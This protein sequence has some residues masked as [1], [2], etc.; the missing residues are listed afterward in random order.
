[1]SKLAHS[2]QETMDEIER[3]SE[4]EGDYIAS[5]EGP[6][7]DKPPA[8][9]SLEELDKCI[10]INE[11]FKARKNADVIIN[12]DRATDIELYCLHAVRD[13]LATAPKLVA[14][15]LL[16]KHFSQAHTDMV[17][18]AEYRE[19]YIKGIHD[20]VSALL[21]GA[22]QSP[23]MD[24]ETAPKDVE[25]LLGWWRSGLERQWECTSGL[26]GST[27]G[28][29]LHGQ[30]THWQPLPA[31]PT[32]NSPQDAKASHNHGESDPSVMP[33]SSGGEQ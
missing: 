3:R 13:G 6:H 25:L 30:A 2:N 15:T 17:G 27:K 5:I 7:E 10:A 29:W 16:N 22:P 8:H 33:D 4:I 18:D 26:A 11:A 9:P 28:G 19:G 31:P 21:I 20:L 23:W 12:P 14:E 1:M 32:H 24:I